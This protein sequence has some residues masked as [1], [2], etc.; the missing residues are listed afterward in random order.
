MKGTRHT[1]HFITI[2]EIVQA[3]VEHPENFND[4]A[5][6][7]VAGVL[8]DLNIYAAQ[9][10]RKLTSAYVTIGILRA[11]KTDGPRFSMN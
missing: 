1:Q 9:L 10:Y 5:L 8:L 6:R 7:D 3:L 4:E 2:N 11:K